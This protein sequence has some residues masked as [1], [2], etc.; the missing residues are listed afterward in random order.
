MWKGMNENENVHNTKEVFDRFQLYHHQK[1]MIK[2]GQIHLLYCEDVCSRSYLSTFVN[3]KTVSLYVRGFKSKA[4][5]HI[6]YIRKKIIMLPLA[7]ELH[8]ICNQKYQK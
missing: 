5:I 2:T 8:F 7:N 4:H 3:M 1:Y 6:L